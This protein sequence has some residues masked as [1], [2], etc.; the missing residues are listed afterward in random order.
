MRRLLADQLGCA[1]RD[2]P[3]IADR[4]GKPWVQDSALRFSA[5]RSAGIAVFA[6]SWTMDVGVDVEAI[7]FGVD[8]DGI[9]A[10]LFSEAEQ[11]SLARVGRAER[12]ASFF[13]CWTRR[14]AYVKATG[15]GL[16]SPV[17]ATEQLWSA[18]DRPRHVSGCWIHSVFVADGFAAAVAGAGLG[19]AKPS[20][21]RQLVWQLSHKN[22]SDV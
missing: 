9:A 2:A 5:A 13:A 4:R 11:R 21:P 12:D 7:R 18:D 10:R 15:A 17:P 20:S 19:D 8:R 3:I 6:T 1:P 14:E 16:G 22:V